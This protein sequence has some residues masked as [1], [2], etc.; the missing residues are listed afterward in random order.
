MIARRVVLRRAVTFALFRSYMDDDRLFQVPDTAE[1]ALKIFYVVTVKR[2][3]VF[4]AQIGE[5]IRVQECAFYSALEFV[6]YFSEMI[7]RIRNFVHEG[8]DKQTE[9]LISAS[10][11]HCGKET[12][13][14][15]SVCR[16]RHL[17]VVQNYDEIPAKNSGIANTFECKPACHC[18]VADHN[19]DFPV[20][21]AC[22]VPCRKKPQS[23]RNRC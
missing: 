18:A 12:G 6:D 8:I 1:N 11:C 17:V 14:R 5:K 9:T 15:A 3:D 20:L 22:K 4:K 19:D 13:K 23:L 21:L 7:L 10:H 16:Y 2:A